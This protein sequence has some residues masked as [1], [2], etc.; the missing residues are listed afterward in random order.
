M[1]LVGVMVI[2]DLSYGEV[3][4]GIEF[5]LVEH[6]PESVDSSKEFTSWYQRNQERN[7]RMSIEKYFTFDFWTRKIT[8]DIDPLT[9]EV[10]KRISTENRRICLI[11]KKEIDNEHTIY[12]VADKGSANA[13]TEISEKLT[14]AV[15]MRRK[16]SFSEDFI[17]YLNNAEPTDKDYVEIFDSDM[18]STSRKAR[19]GKHRIAEG[20]LDL[21]MREPT[22]HEQ[23]REA[24]GVRI[25][26]PTN[27]GKQLPTMEVILY[28][29]GWVN[30]KRPRR[31][32]DEVTYYEAILYGIS[33]LSE[34]YN[35]FSAL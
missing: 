19:K 30:F 26:P 17:E 2:K 32:D 25:V 34:S 27:L 18:E 3:M 24:A 21:S 35:K 22:I 14:L 16:I 23:F 13:I 6:G 29:N 10:T 31:E 4:K 5:F 1:T 15:S 28:N 7:G 33:R 9:K 12:L 20:Y 11:N 8:Q